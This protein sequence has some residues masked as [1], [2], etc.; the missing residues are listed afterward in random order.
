MSDQP[1]H[2]LHIFQHVAAGHITSEDGAEWMMGVRYRESYDRLSRVFD[3]FLVGNMIAW[4]LVGWS[5][6]P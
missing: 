3:I 1:K 6:T 5:R 2:H 4:F